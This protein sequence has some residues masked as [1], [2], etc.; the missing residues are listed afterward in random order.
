[1][2]SIWGYRWCGNSGAHEEASGY[3]GS[4]TKD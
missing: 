3:A 2:S 4:L 1:L